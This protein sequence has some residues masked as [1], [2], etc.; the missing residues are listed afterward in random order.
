[1][2]LRP[3]W[4]YNE[5]PLRHGMG[6]SMQCPAHR[7]SPADVVCFWFV[8]PQDGGDPLTIGGE[9][10]PDELFDY[11]GRTFAELTVWQALPFPDEAVRGPHWWGYIAKGYVYSCPRWTGL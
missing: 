4:I 3:R 1:M 8:R 5:E 11:E 7:D 10:K 9:R 6:F 2:H